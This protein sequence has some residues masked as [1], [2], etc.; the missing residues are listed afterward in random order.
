MHR[1]GAKCAFGVHQSCVA[2]IVGLVRFWLK[3]VLHDIM[4]LH[5]IMYNMIIK[6]KSYLNTITREVLRT[7]F[8]TIAITIDRCSITI[9]YCSKFKVEML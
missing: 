7:S 8:P 1:K 9:I 2:I 4:I 6:Y 3:G 5:M